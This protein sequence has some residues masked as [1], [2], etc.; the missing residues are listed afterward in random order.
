MMKFNRLFATALLS[1]SL[2]LSGC[3]LPRTAVEPEFTTLPEKATFPDEEKIIG[4]DEKK[5]ILSI[6]VSEEV[7]VPTSLEKSDPLP[8]IRID[9]FSAV[10]ATVMETF[11]LLLLD[12]D[13]PVSGD[14]SFTDVRVNIFDLKGNLKDVLDR[15]SEISGVYYTYKNGIITV[16]PVRNF[17]VPLPPIQDSFAGIESIIAEMGGEA[18]K[19]DTF[20]RLL[21][22]RANRQVYEDVT[23]YLSRLKKDKAMVVY[24]TYIIEVQLD[25][26]KNIGINWEALN[27]DIGGTSFGLTQGTDVAGVGSLLTFGAAYSGNNFSIDPVV[28]FLQTQGTV[29]ILSKPTVAMISGGTATFE[30]GQEQAYISEVESTVEDDGADATVSTTTTT[31]TLVTGLKLE[32]VADY[33]DET[34]FSNI[35]LEIADLINLERVDIPT[36]A[37]ITLGGT[38]ESVDNQITLPTTTTRNLSTMVRA[39]PGDTILLAGINQSRDEAEREGFPGQGDYL[40]GFYARF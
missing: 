5:P 4:T 40:G 17:I 38:E 27:F 36:G 13:I 34:V 14:P 22:F 37:T 35:N 3:Q 6:P 26:D 15:V 25:D 32:V 19:V 8:D 23:A 39:R 11:R 30:V 21:T 18:V 16:E 24:E 33:L 12:K 9:N 2:V 10:D 28:S 1:S 29:E 7:L 31:E 20:A